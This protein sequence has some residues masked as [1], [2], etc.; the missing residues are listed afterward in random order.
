MD[1]TISSNLKVTFTTQIS[2]D[3]LITL[4]KTAEKETQPIQVILDKALRLY[5]QTHAKKQDSQHHV[6]KALQASIC[7]Y[8]SLYK[9]KHNR[10]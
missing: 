2:P 10:H 3:L 1:N 9:E 8:Q 5:F 7:Q 6:L 4:K